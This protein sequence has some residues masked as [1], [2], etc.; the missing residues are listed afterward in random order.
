MPHAYERIRRA[1]LKDSSEKL[2]ALYHHVYNVEHLRT[3]YRSLRRNAAPGVDRVTWQQ[4]GEALEENLSDLADRLR[5]KAYRARP[6]RRTYISKT[7]GRLRPL[8]VTALEDKI[9]QKVATEVLN[10]I[11]EP[12]FLGFSYGF[13]PKR[14]QHNALDA[15]WVGL[16]Q[17][18]VNWVL[19]ADV[20]GFFDCLNHSWLMRFV[21]H[22]ISDRYFLRLLRKWLNAGV[23]EDGSW[24]RQTKGSPQ[25]AVVSPVLA[26]VYLHY[27]FDLWAHAW[28]RRAKG[29]VI[30]VRYADDLV[31]GF[32]YRED[33][34]RFRRDLA[35][36]FA[37]FDLELHPEKT[38]L[39]E[40]GRFAA[41]DRQARGE[42]RPDTF[43]FLGFTHVCGTTRKRKKFVVVRR[44]KRKKWQAK[45]R[46]L[47]KELRK[48]MHDSVPKV[49]AW[50]RSVLTGH[51]RYYGVPL[52]GS[53]LSLFRFKLM[54]LWR[55][56]LRRRSQRNRIT[57]A[58]MYRLSDRWLPFAKI[59]HPW[60][61]ARL[62]VTT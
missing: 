6:V 19:D 44:T 3:A 7:D 38:R 52:N 58:R 22:R 34:E 14:S 30:L 40:F 20:S 37:K 23:L 26:N 27:V 54:R 32:Q 41:R 35:E 53:A 55:Q 36:R 12:A 46:E 56:V 59:Y 57:W 42:G 43:D 50:L 16:T 1:V 21:E 33:A 9:V 48:R 17:K 28:R 24:T 45:L 29:E 10:A 5:R 13:R 47:K 25:G 18:K 62:L 51:Y 15:L 4:Y 39:V 11:F 8:G 49:G 31:V 2:T 60:P 61:N